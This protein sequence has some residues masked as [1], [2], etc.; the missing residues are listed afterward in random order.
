MEIKRH[1]KLFLWAA[2]IYIFVFLSG[3][4]TYALTEAAKLLA[5]DGAARDYFGNSVAISGDGVLVGA[6]RDDDKGSAYVFR[7]NGSTWVQEQK[8]L[9]SDGAFGDRFGNSVTIKEDMA[10]VGAYG[11]DTNGNTAGAVYVFRWNGTSWVEGQKLLASDGAVGER[12][13]ISVVIS[14]NIALVGATADLYLG[15]GIG[16]VYVFRWNGNTWVEQQ[17]LLASDGAAGDRFGNSVSVSGDVALIGAYYDYDNGPESGSAYVFRWNGSNWVEE[18]KLLSSDGSAGNYFGKSVSISGDVALVGVSGDN[19]NGSYSGSA[20]IFRYNGTS[21]VEEQKLLASDGAIGDEFGTSAAINGDTALVGATATTYSGSVDGLGS[22][23]IFRRNGNIWEQERKLTPSDPGVDNY[24]G[25][26]VSLS[27]DLAMVGAVGDADNGIESGSAYI[28]DLA[29]ISEA[30]IDAPPG[31]MAW[32]PGDGGPNDI[33]GLRETSLMYGA[34][35]EM[36]MVGQAFSFDGVDDYVVAHANGI[37]ELQQFT[38]DFWVKHKSLLTDQVFRYV[39]PL[40]MKAVLQYYEGKLE[41]Y[42][43]NV[44]L[45]SEFVRVQMDFQIGKFYHI[46]GIYDGSSMRLYLDGQLIG[47]N[48]VPLL[49]ELAIADAV[50]MSSYD[51]SIHGLI[52]EV[53]IFNRALSQA[54]IQAIY[55]AGSD[56]KCKDKIY[57]PKRRGGSG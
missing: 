35:F 55:D 11:E 54:E 1:N 5:S 51:E 10:L 33:I 9:A 30:C 34:S 37:G 32:W 40:P 36:G 52:D 39:T 2:F 3:S 31:M 15:D 41:F 8:L 20:Y 4:T 6:P 49:G 43:T 13:G 46:A 56:G 53:E 44:E 7:W 28:Y 17:K 24:F 23:Y 50:E 25:I 57:D 21:W 29:A 14:G 47:A 27:G 48:N 45:R 16:A 26:S 12:F 18:Q 38:I 42:I 22:A 19:D